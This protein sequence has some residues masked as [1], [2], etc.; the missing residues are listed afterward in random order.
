M[1]LINVRSSLI[2]F[3]GWLIGKCIDKDVSKNIIDWYRWKVWKWG[4][5]S[6]CI[7]KSG[8]RHRQVECVKENPNLEGNDEI[9]TN[10]KECCGQPPKN[11]ELCNSSKP[12][13]KTRDIQMK[14]CKALLIWFRVQ[15]YRVVSFSCSL[16]VFCN[17]LNLW[18]PKCYIFHLP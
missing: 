7:F 10:S 5:C 13:P 12:C 2:N 4:P 18:K 16:F 15:L 17:L 11:V 3:K 8:V 1:F 9:I 6:G 14:V